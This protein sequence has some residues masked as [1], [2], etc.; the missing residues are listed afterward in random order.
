MNLQTDTDLRKT[1]RRRVARK[2]G[3]FIHLLVFVLV[4]AGL[5]LINE[6]HGGYRWSVWPLG[7][8]ALGLGIHGLVTFLGLA[9]EGWRQRMIDA[10]LERLQRQ[11]R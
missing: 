1:A 11:Q 2:I 4:N 8:W 3:F 9:G 6:M 5:W 10:E 7:G